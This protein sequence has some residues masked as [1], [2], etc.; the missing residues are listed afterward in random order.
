MDATLIKI[1]MERKKPGKNKPLSPFQK[2]LP[3]GPIMSTDEFNEY[4]KNN[5]WMG[6]WKK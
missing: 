3:E 4:K 1:K 2:K 6:K 5:K